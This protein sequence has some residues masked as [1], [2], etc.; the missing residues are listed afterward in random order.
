[1][2]S[3]SLQITPAQS[4]GVDDSYLVEDSNLQ[5]FQFNAEKTFLLHPSVLADLGRM[6]RQAEKDGVAIAI[7]SSYRSFAAQL[8]IWNGKWNG[9][10]SVFSPQGELLKLDELSDRQKFKAI[11]H[12]SALPGLSRHH[13]GSDLDIFD[14]AALNNGYQPQLLPEEFC[15]GGVCH[16]LENWL[17][18]N[19]L[20][21][22]FFR[23]YD[24]YRGGV[25]AEPWHI[26]HVSTSESIM[27]QF[28]VDYC[29]T[30]LQ[31]SAIA[32]KDFIDSQFENYYENYFCNICKVN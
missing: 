27:Q 16:K 26:S 15:S 11:S 12:W 20:E 2:R 6:L 1:M 18:N 21:F 19:L 5:K 13:W 29:K 24:K 4:I 14:L 10:K 7:V 25:A 3:A 22:G 9:E 28:D 30:Y 31:Q 32:A 23:P 17:Q 8:K